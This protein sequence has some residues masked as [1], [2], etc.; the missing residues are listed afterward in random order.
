MSAIE[1]TSQETL[2]KPAAS[3]PPLSSF[4]MRFLELLSSVRFGI[5]LLALLVALS[6]TGML[7]M[8][9]EIDGFD[10]YFAELTPSQRL[11]YGSL[12]LFDIYHTWYFNLLLLVLS[13]NIILASIDRFPKAWTFIARPKLDASPHWLR[14]QKPSAT[15]NIAGANLS[16]VA[17]RVAAAAKATGFKTRITEKAGRTFVFAERGRWNRLGAYAVHVALLLLFL[18]SFVSNYFE[19]TGTIRM[20]PRTS[21]KAMMQTVFDQ[22]QTRQNSIPL[23]FTVECTDIQQRLREKDGDIMA[24]NTIDWITR[25]RIND[26]GA[27]REATISLN[28]P[29]DYRGYRFFQAS[30]IPQGSARD[31]T[32]LLTPAAG[33]APVQVKVPRYGETTIADGT[34]IGYVEFFPDFALSGS[35]PGTTSNDYNNP[36]VQLRITPPNGSPLNGY[37]FA[38]QLPDG[39]PVGAP[40]GGYKLRLVEFEKVPLAH[41]LSVKHDPLYGSTIAWYIGGPLLILTLFGV[42]FFSHERVWAAI[43]ERTEGDY[44]VVLGGNTNRNQINL[45]DRFAKIVNAVSNNSPTKVQQS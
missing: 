34:R 21:A 36:A 13:L 14:G 28:N 8:Q 43:S 7:I 4:V 38:Q 32:L 26:N 5:V 30:F 22:D 41:I 6:M 17:E 18:G 10:R 3:S 24:G 27:T 16:A 33:G 42:F 9:Q 37:A 44:E 15:L 45:E 11:L 1:K 12:G 39:A 40:I 19:R 20:I 29:T 35:R 23:P 31:V 2:I 25:V